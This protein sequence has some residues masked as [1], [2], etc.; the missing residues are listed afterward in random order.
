M[1][2]DLRRQFASATGVLSVAMLAASAANYALNLGLARLL[3]R[4]QF[5]DATLIV[6]L[7]L[8]LTAAGVGLQ[9]VTARRRRTATGGERSGLGSRRRPGLR[10]GSCSVRVTAPP[11]RCS[12][13]SSRPA[14]RCPSWCS[15]VGLPVYLV[16]SV[17]R[18]VLQ[19]RLAFGRLAATFAVE[20]PCGW[21]AASRS[22]QSGSESPA[23]PPR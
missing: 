3:D 16:Q 2:S 23:R 8:G 22:S 6:T 15:R 12:S 9:L 10:A 5:G 13:S 20:A 21:S 7:L 19:G 1:T 14:P 17:D 4:P 18:G 11:H